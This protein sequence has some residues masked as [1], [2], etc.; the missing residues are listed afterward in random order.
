LFLVLYRAQQIDYILLIIV[1]ALTALEG[2]K[3]ALLRILIMLFLWINHPLF[4]HRKNMI[5]W[6]KLFAPLGAL[7]S[8]SVVFIVLLK[9]NDSSQD[10]NFAFIRRIIYGADAI[11]TFYLPVNEQFF[12]GIHFWDYPSHFFN[13]VLA[14]LKIVPNHEAFGNVM[15]ANAFPNRV[16]TIVGPNTPYY[17]EGQIFFGY[18]GAFVY[19]LLIGCCYAV[20]RNYFFN[21]KFY[22]AFWLIL[23]CCICQQAGALYA[24][25]TYFTIS[26]FYSCFFVIPVYILISL[27]TQ[28]KISFYLNNLSEKEMCK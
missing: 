1:I 5:K 15:V 25:V 26:A 28:G 6:V 9:E 3:S 12:A 11:L 13:Q 2:S 23:S 21:H 4:R 7:V 18:Y 14:F 10:A 17:I 8:F 20:I 24:E 19:S 16:G 27:F 22:S